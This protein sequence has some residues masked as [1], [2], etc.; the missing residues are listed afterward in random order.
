[1]SLSSSWH[2][3][4]SCHFRRSRPASASPA[5]WESGQSPPSSRPR[6]R[7]P[8]SGWKPSHRQ[9][10]TVKPPARNQKRTT[11]RTAGVRRLANAG[12]RRGREV[13]FDSSRT[14]SSR[15]GRPLARQEP[16][17]KLY[18]Y[19]SG[20]NPRPPEPL[21]RSVE[22]RSRVSGPR[23]AR[24]QDCDCRW[25]VPINARRL[26]STR[27]T[28]LAGLALSAPALAPEYSRSPPLSSR[29]SGEGGKAR[30][31]ES[32]FCMLGPCVAGNTNSKK[33]ETKKEKRGRERVGFPC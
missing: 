14:D 4:S 26:H 12:E 21:L 16:A 13:V 11:R 5:P 6:A 3:P 7:V 20:K 15:R 33:I 24:P 2:A 19:S 27:L 28:S 31:R 1:M 8:C 22:R 32:S 23:G 9:H 29:S 17:D 18:D 30:A 25:G 10:S